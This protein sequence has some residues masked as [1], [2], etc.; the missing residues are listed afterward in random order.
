MSSLREAE[1]RVGPPPRISVSWIVEETLSFYR[2]KFASL[3][4]IFLLFSLAAW[5]AQ[6]YAGVAVKGIMADYNVSIGEIA[7]NPEQMAPLIFQMGVRIFAAGLALAVVLWVL[8]LFAYG[9]TV[10]YTYDTYVDGETSWYDSFSRVVPLLPK[11]FAATLV[12]LVI[13]SLGLIIFVVPGIILLLMFCLVPQAIVI[14]G[15]GV[16]E[17]LGR[18]GNITSGN[19]TTILL[20]LLFWVVLGMLVNFAVGS[21]VGPRWVPTASL[22]VNAILGPV[23]P[24]S[25]TIIYWALTGQEER[26]ALL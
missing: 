21:L 1:P 6:S 4:T 5:A 11:L 10:R 25:T 2:E 19:K 26:P 9:S 3:F 14:E 15:T 22:I 17:A 24:I 20:F 7:E 12:A 16:I 13:V 8:Y 18:S 23:I